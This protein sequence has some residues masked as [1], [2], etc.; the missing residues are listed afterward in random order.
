MKI[1]NQKSKIEKDVAPAVPSGNTNLG[2]VSNDQ[3]RVKSMN[4]KA[5]KARKKIKL[6]RTII[7]RIR[8]KIIYPFNSSG[9]KMKKIKT[10]R[11]VGK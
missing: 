6:N 10:V 1:E 5:R 7:I 8:I 2:L 3:S 4:C 11:V 9:E